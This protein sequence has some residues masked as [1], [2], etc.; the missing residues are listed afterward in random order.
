[1]DAETQA[2]IRQ[3]A[4]RVDAAREDAAERIRW[5]AEQHEREWRDA[6]AWRSQWA[7]ELDAL[8]IELD[9]LKIAVRALEQHDMTQ[10][11]ETQESQNERI[12]R[13]VNELTLA[14]ADVLFELVP[15]DR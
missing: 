13:K 8:E 4:A 5:L 2:A 1:M 7:A 15:L 14:F 12:Y 9:L 3:L 6:A 10:P 11:D